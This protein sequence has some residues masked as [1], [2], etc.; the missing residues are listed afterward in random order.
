M[1][2]RVFVEGI[3]YTPDGIEAIRQELIKYR[4][5]AYDQMPDTAEFI[6]VIS[7]VLALLADYAE[8]RKGEL[9][10]DRN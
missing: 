5:A 6:V 2:D 3:D 8:L 9:A 10:R 4:S 7:H 1:T